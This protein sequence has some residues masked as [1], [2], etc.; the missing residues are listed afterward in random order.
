MPDHPNPAIT[1]GEVN[2]ELAL[3]ILMWI[4]VFFLAWTAT[5]ILYNID[6]ILDCKAEHAKLDLAARKRY[7]REYNGR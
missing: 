3:E 6:Q 1:A 4:G 7:D 5:S 2:M